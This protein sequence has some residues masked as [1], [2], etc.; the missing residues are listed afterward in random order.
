M[1]HPLRHFYK[2]SPRLRRLNRRLKN[3]AAAGLASGALWLV[4]RLSLE[5][6]LWLGERVGAL[7]YRV[8]WGTR[9]LAIEH[10]RVAFGDTLTDGARARLARASFINIARCFCELA[11]IDEIRARRDAYF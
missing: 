9:R 8:L 2:A 7:L 10:L 6:A 4:G 11:K 3:A 1:S 5:R